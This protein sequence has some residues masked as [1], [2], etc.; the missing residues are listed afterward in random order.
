MF[1][2]P[3][4]LTSPWTATAALLVSLCFGLISVI[5]A[6]HQTYFLNALSFRRNPV[7]QARRIIGAAAGQPQ[8]RVRTM[9]VFIWQLPQL[10]L[11]YS[12]FALYIGLTIIVTH[13]LLRQDRWGD[14]WKVSHL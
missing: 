10:A 4:L 2:W 11:C 7:E 5:T 1:Q 3:Q 14:E 13:P 6:L 12:I 8:L 9:G